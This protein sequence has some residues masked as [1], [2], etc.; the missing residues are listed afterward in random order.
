MTNVN[1]ATVFITGGAQGIGLGLGRAFAELGARLALVDVDPAGLEAAKAE[2]E[3][4][5]T[6]QTYEADV[7]DIQSVIRVADQAEEDLGPVSV[8]CNN[9][10][11]GGV[12][13]LHE[14]GFALWDAVWQV[15]LGGTVNTLK[16][17]LPRMLRRGGP[18]HIVNIASGAGVVQNGYPM[19]TGSKFA[20][21]GISEALAAHPELISA[22]IGVTVAFPSMVQTSIFQ[23]SAARHDVG[24]HGRRYA[25]Q[26][27]SLL[28]EAGIAPDAVGRQV[29]DAVSRNQLFVHTDRMLVDA[30]ADRGA[31]LLAA[32]PPE[33]E[34]DRQVAAWFGRREK[35]RS[36]TAE[37]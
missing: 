27:D 20:V 19:Y 15:N 36:A 2:L 24:E 29:V 34:R 32:M 1:D 30:I 18:G 17:F 11:V 13:H 37:A 9:A 25:E 14:D 6:V 23:N 16:A 8:L 33:T 26:G 10:G 7:A 31:R 22:G 35:E 3:T 28:Q 4:T 5:T 12:E 21:A